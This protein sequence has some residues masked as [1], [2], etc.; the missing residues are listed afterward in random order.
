MFSVCDVLIPEKVQY[1]T[2]LCTC[3]APISVSV[4]LGLFSDDWDTAGDRMAFDV[5]ELLTV[6][7]VL[8]TGVDAALFFAATAASYNTQNLPI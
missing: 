8:E 6:V 5:D 2:A 7:L 1:S 3:W 4:T